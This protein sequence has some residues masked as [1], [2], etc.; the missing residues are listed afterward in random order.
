MPYLL[1]RLSEPQG[2]T[3]D[4]EFDLRRAVCEQ[5]QR[6]VS[7]HVWPGPSGLE[8]MG[9]GLPQLTGF[10]YAGKDDLTR[11]ARLIREQVL[12]HEPRLQGVC[13]SLRSRSGSTQP[14][15]VLVSGHLVDQPQAETF[16]FDLPRH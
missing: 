11:Y 1:E 10:G 15:Q 8:L 16:S 9:I 6:V 12:R 14:Y 13:V 2:A 5:I 4:A 3:S 7:T